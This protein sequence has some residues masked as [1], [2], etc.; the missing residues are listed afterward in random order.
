MGAIQPPTDNLYKFLAIGGLLIALYSFTFPQVRLNQIEQQR[1][2]YSGEKQSSNKQKD[3]LK[4]QQSTITAETKQLE[5]RVASLHDALRQPRSDLHWANQPSPFTPSATTDLTTAQEQL[6][7]A[8]AALR[9]NERQLATIDEAINTNT[10]HEAATYNQAKPYHDQLLWSRL[11]ALILMATGFSLWFRRAQRY[12]DGLLKMRY[13][14]ARSKY[15]SIAPSIAPSAKPP[16]KTDQP[17][18]NSV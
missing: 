6:A 11:F 3:V 13:E 17:Q 9:E 7:S 18:A 1:I 14:S 4:M 16:E 12:E 2:T 15:S 10:Q 5:A 8:Q